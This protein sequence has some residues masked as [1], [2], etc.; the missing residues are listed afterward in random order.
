MIHNNSKKSSFCCALTKDSLD[1]GCGHLLTDSLWTRGDTAADLSG[2]DRRAGPRSNVCSSI[3][4]RACGGLT[5]P[6]GGL[7]EHM[8][9]SAVPNVIL[10]AARTR[11]DPTHVLSLAH[12]CAFSGCDPKNLASCHVFE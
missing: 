6:S 1:T 8:E 10:P 9:L 2:W 3:W 5:C 12:F 7:G 11:A 4:A